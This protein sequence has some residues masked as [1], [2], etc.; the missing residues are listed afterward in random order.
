[1]KEQSATI[2]ASKVEDICDKIPAFKREIDWDR[3]KTKMS[4][5][6][7]VIVFK[8]GST[9]ENVAAT[10]RSRGLRKHSGVLEECVGIDQDML[11]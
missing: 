1:M 10:E 11:Q 3:G 8:N 4:K 2:L 9:I 6:H 5:D 7:T